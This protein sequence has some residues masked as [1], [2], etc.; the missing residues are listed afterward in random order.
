MLKGL[1]V[2]C[3]QRYVL[4]GCSNI[5]FSAKK[6]NISLMCKLDLCYKLQRAVT[7]HIQIELT[8]DLPH[9]GK[10]PTIVRR[11]KAILMIA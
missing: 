4:L 3:V 10:G 8:E 7:V 9:V 6:S 5:L 11:G 2:S 1:V